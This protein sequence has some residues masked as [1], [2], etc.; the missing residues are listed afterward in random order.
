[1]KNII[2]FIVI[3][4]FNFQLS[5]SQ[6]SC[7]NSQGEISGPL[8]SVYSFANWASVCAPDGEGEK[9]VEFEI[10]QDSG[11]LSSYALTN[12]WFFW[13]TDCETGP[14]NWQEG[15]VNISDQNIILE[16]GQCL[17]FQLYDY[18]GY[19]NSSTNYSLTANLFEAKPGPITTPV[20]R[21]DDAISQCLVKH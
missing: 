5:Y 8:T 17:Y 2:S 10:I 7:E 12:L 16:E 18:Y 14:V 9:I 13:S 4:I 6:N 1:M 11:S 3:L 20:I 19:A 15:P 21:I